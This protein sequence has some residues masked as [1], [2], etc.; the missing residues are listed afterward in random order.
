MGWQSP[1]NLTG[2]TWCP[3]EGKNY[4]SSRG[5][6]LLIVCLVFE[7]N[8][9]TNPSFVV[10]GSIRFKVKSVLFTLG[11]GMPAISLHGVFVKHYLKHLSTQHT[12][13]QNL[14]YKCVNDATRQPKNASEA[15]FGGLHRFSTRFNCAND[16]TRQPNVAWRVWRVLRGAACVAWR[17]RRVWRVWRVWRR[18]MRAACA[19]WWRQTMDGTDARWRSAVFKSMGEPAA[20]KQPTPVIESRAQPFSSP[21]ASQPLEKQLTALIERLWTRADAQPLR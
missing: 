17:V 6:Y 12:P 18:V 14:W 19:Y 1:I 7:N 9:C 5:M 2:D 11:A 8:M 13:P 16:A 15:K 10:L 21:W 20:G 3:W 4:S